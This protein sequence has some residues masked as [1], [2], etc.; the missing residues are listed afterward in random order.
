MC[1]RMLKF[2]ETVRHLHLGKICSSKD[3]HR[4]KIDTAEYI[5]SLFKIWCKQSVIKCHKRFNISVELWGNGWL[6]KKILLV[7][8]FRSKDYSKQ[9]SA[10]IQF[11]IQMSLHPSVWHTGSYSP[12]YS[13]PGNNRMWVYGYGHKF[14]EEIMIN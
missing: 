13:W 2:T 3:L 14:L 12:I 4:L 7:K 8:F 5:F 10:W 1:I 9:R 11:V 6:K